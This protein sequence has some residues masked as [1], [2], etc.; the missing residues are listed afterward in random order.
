MSE[1]EVPISERMRIDPPALIMAIHVRRQWARNGNTTSCDR[2]VQ[3]ER[4]PNPGDLVIE[5]TAIPRA[6]SLGL[7]KLSIGRMIGTGEAHRKFS[8]GEKNRNGDDTYVERLTFIETLDGKCIYW[9]NCRFD[10]LLTYGELMEAFADQPEDAA[11]RK[12]KA[13]WVED[14]LTRHRISERITFFENRTEPNFQT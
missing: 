10:R 3:L 14:A 7:E 9:T 8:D 2:L 13:D 11:T 5:M 4:S 6:V 1:E 12:K